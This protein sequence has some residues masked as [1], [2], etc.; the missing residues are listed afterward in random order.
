M[1]KIFKFGKEARAEI[2]KGV[3]LIADVVGATLG[4]AGRLA[5][6]EEPQDMAPSISKDGVF[7]ARHVYIEDPLQNLGARL[8]KDVAAKTVAQVGDGTTSACILARN[9]FNEGLVALD[10]GAN[11]HELKKQID[12][13][14]RLVAD[15][16]KAHALP[17]TPER[18]RAIA[19]ISANNDPAIGALM[20]AAKTKAGK[21]GIIVLADNIGY[22]TVIETIDGMQLERGY[23]DQAFVTD[24]AKDQCILTNVYILLW[25]K[26]LT[27]ISPAIELLKQIQSK[28]GSLLVICEDIEGDALEVLKTN[29]VRNV[30]KSCA[31]KTPGHPAQRPGVLQDIAAMTGAEAITSS[32]DMDIK[33]VMFHHLGLAGKVVI[34][35]DKTL[36]IDA[37]GHEYGIQSRINELRSLVSGA[38]GNE[39]DL[40]Q[41]RLAALSG[42]MVV[43]KVG[44]RTE[45]EAS[46]LKFRVE[47][48]MHACSAAQEMG[49][50]PGG[51]VALLKCCHIVDKDGGDIGAKIVANACFIPTE[52]IVK[53]AGYDPTPVIIAVGLH[54]NDNWGFNALTGEYEDLLD[55]GVLDPA[56]VVITALENAASIA[57]LLLTC[58]VSIVEK[59]PSEAAQAIAM[60]G[61]K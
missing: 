51:G 47:D 18:I 54:P 4:P 30:L 22:D 10:A 26:K 13:A 32:L 61:I 40:L 9:I 24:R 14:V 43:I 38:T 33:D 59:R 23:A 19:T 3:N 5:I 41:K 21:D 57:C 11:P 17:I 15:E 58:E 60:L 27:A 25:E 55:A 48:A 52:T 20:L 7:C 2:Q 45:N 39:K 31:I 56:K 1:A 36:I 44:A 46:E 50:V 35:R 37:A 49:V 6:I 12:A 53:N 28:G 8:V 34:D 29:S 42:G 16:I